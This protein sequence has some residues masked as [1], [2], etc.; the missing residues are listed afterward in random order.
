MF[1]DGDNGMVMVSAWGSFSEAKN[2]ARVR[3]VDRGCCRFFAQVF[4]PSQT[5]SFMFE[6]SSVALLSPHTL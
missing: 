5:W 4:P 3:F 2:K 6:L 1:I